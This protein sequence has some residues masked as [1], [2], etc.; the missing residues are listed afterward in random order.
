M[1]RADGTVNVSY[2]A[3]GFP[4]FS[5]EG[6]TARETETSGGSR[7]AGRQGGSPW[8]RMERVAF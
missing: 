4:A 5:T 1:L 8:V 7:S 2:F 6:P 3:Q